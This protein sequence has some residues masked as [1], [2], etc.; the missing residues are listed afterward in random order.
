M[1]RM[2]SLELEEDALG[3]KNTQKPKT[4]KSGVAQINVLQGN[5]C[6]LMELVSNVIPTSV[7]VKIGKLVFL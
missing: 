1:L 5:S 3:A 2:K 7:L 6:R 4:I